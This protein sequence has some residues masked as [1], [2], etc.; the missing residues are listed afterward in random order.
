MKTMNRKRRYGDVMMEDAFVEFTV[1]KV[2]KHFMVRVNT[3]STV[4]GATNTDGKLC[5]ILY[6]LEVGLTLLL[7]VSVHTN[8]KLLKLIMFEQHSK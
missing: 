5:H 2:K 1:I 4:L 3:C 8:H 7:A 6:I